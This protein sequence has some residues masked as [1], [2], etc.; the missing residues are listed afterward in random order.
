MGSARDK[1]DSN[2]REKAQCRVCR[3]YYHRVDVHVGEVHKMD[4]S[5]YSKTYPGASLY[6][7]YARKSV[8]FARDA[9]ATRKR[10]KKKASA[11]DGDT[12]RFGVAEV[13]TRSGLDAHDLQYVPLHDENWVPGPTEEVNLEALALGIQEDENILIVGPPGV[14][15]TTLARELAAITSNPLRRLP[16]NGEMRVSDL[17]GA[18]NL[19]VD[20][21]S[22]QTVTRWNDGPLVDAAQRGHWVLL[23]E[24]DSVPPQVGFVLHSVLER[25]R[26]LA[27]MGKEGGAEVEFN[28]EFRVI[29]T[30]N[31]LGY[32]DETGLYAGT[33]PLNEALLDRFGIVIRVD[34]PAHAAE[35]RILTERTGL[36]S[37][38]A[39]RM[40][41]VAAA[42]REAQK[43]NQTMVSMSTRR[44]IMWASKARRLSPQRAAELTITNKLPPDDGRYVAGIIQRHF[45]TTA[46][47]GSGKTAR[48]TVG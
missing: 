36:E 3:K 38:V 14:G 4:V 34:Y 32:G 46:F 44:L 45:G 35:V 27:I 25:P 24:F 1:H 15:K 37:G 29:A 7:E 16:C 23:D 41:Q 43:N 12:Y 19:I 6:S 20:K 31:T 26:Q 11:S 13:P 10:A 47:P 2:G 30:A 33:G 28:K 5:E 40:V 8:E 17:L 18:Q 21:D 48:R 9:A 42:I 22:G 39:D